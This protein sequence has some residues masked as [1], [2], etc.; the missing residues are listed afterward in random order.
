LPA[1]CSASWACPTARCSSLRMSAPCNTQFCKKTFDM[2][3]FVNYRHCSK[4]RFYCLKNVWNCIVFSTFLSPCIRTTTTFVFNTHYA[5]RICR[6]L[7]GFVILWP[8][9]ACKFH[10]K[11]QKKKTSKRSFSRF[12]YLIQDV[13]C[14]LD[15]IDTW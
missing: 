5:I 4:K 9:I 6:I 15:E 3:Y 12:S 8:K 2:N 14:L 11:T 1:H 7:C 13:L 10:K